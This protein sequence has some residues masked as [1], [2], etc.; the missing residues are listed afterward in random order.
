MSSEISFVNH[1][2]TGDIWTLMPSKFHVLHLR[3]HDAEMAELSPTSGTS[4][5]ANGNLCGGYEQFGA[6]AVGTKPSAV[7]H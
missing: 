7:S 1:A 2:C 4:P 6:F 5:D 3:R